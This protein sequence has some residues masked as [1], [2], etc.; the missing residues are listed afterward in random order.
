MD[1]TA[2]GLRGCA[3]AVAHRDYAEGPAGY[4]VGPVAQRAAVWL[5]RLM[6]YA[7]VEYGMRR[8]YGLAG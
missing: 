5:K 7:V 6:P 2:L 4:T 1:R 3:L 8:Y